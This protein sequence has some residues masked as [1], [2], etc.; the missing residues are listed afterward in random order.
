MPTSTTPIRPAPPAAAARCACED[1]LGTCDP[2]P[3]PRRSLVRRMV[4]AARRAALRFEI[5]STEQYLAQAERDG[6]VVS[7]TVVEWGWL[8]QAKR[9]ELRE[10]EQA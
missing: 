3:A 10:L 2:T 6:I 1:C 9:A 4:L 7:D 8:L 5:S